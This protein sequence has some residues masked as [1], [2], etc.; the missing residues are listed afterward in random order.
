MIEYKHSCIN[1]WVKTC[2]KQLPFF[3]NLISNTNMASISVRSENLYNNQEKLVGDYFLYS[4]N[5]NVWFMGYIV[6]RI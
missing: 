4:H 3:I 2:I 6:G 1:L 5:L